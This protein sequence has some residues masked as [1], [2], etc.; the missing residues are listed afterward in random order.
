MALD[1]EIR[2]LLDAIASSGNYEL[3][4][5]LIE[6]DREAALHMV[7]FQEPPVDLPRIE[8][9]SIPGRSGPI[10]ARI[11]WPLEDAADLPIFLFWHGGGWQMG[12][13][14]TVDR[15]VR[16]FASR[17][18]VIV[19]SAAL[20]LAPENPYP[21]AVEDGV[22][23]LDWVAAEASR[24][25]GDPDRI[26]VGGESSGGNIA[27]AV[28]LE[29]RA[30]G[31][32]QIAHQFLITPSLDPDEDRPSIREF[33]SGHLLTAQMQRLTRSRYYGP[34][35]TAIAEAGEF[36]RLPGTLAPLRAGDLTGLPPATIITC[37]CDPVRDE[38]EA[39]A[40]ALA[41]AGVEVR[42][43]RF[44]GLTHG[45]LNLAAAIPSAEEYS[46]AVSRMLADAARR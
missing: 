9:V 12:G 14:E 18:E 34:E 10:A 43:R 35:L 24:L 8:D 25:G 22:A 21:A 41:D 45:S 6:Q 23:A 11:Y 2:K 13:I 40:S 46:L 30:A 3:G 7:D 33:G 38:G 29:A 39:Y 15:P 44:E 36:E 4:T 20:R 31:G 26:L 17:G 28:S 32:P 16:G 5:G 27:A 1:P 19:V 37:E 42:Q